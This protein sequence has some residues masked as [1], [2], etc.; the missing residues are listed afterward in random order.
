VVVFFAVP[1]L[2]EKG[3]KV[4]SL[5]PEFETLFFLLLAPLS[6]RRGDKGRVF[7]LIPLF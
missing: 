1:L 2:K 5:N 6:L 7:F 3:I 4:G